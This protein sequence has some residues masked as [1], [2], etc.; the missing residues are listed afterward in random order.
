MSSPEGRKL[1]RQVKEQA[2]KP[3]DQRKLR[4]LGRRIKR[5]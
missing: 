3:E 2:S 4:D 5:R 1:E